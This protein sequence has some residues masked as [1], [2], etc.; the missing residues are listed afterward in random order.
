MVLVI[1]EMR[2]RFEGRGTVRRVDGDTGGG[3]EKAMDGGL[4]ASESD[5]KVVDSAL[6]ELLVDEWYWME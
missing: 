6:E 4:V 2:E 1:R 3:K 5:A